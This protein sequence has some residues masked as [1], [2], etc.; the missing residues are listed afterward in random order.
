MEWKKFS[1]SLK[2]GDEQIVT[3]FLAGGMR[4]ET[5]E[6]DGRSLAIML[7]LN[8]FN[9]EK[10]VDILMSNHFD[11]NQTFKQYAPGGDMQTNLL[12]SAIEHGNVKL[13]VA[14][15]KNKINPNKPVD[16]YGMMGI[17]TEKYPLQ[18]AI[19]WKQTDIAFLIL[20]AKCDISVGNYAAYQEAYFSRNNYFW[21]NH[22]EDMQKILQATMPP[23]N[24][25][26]K[27]NAE[28]RLGEIDAE[29]TDVAKKSLQSYGKPYQKNEYDKK[30]DELLAE[31][32]KLLAIVK[33]AQE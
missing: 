19:Y 7:A 1:R 16:T 27:I 14:L 11:I 23:Q 32:Q 9:P 33:K 2:D 5:A 26:A 13:V 24:K 12:G 18:S 28:L 31:K 10:M 15:L 21:K 4:A 20:K 25:S 3:L 22:Q 30:Y 29:L 8:T 6:S 17:A